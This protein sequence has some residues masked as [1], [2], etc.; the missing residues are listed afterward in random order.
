M[1]SLQENKGHR[2]IAQEPD[3][4]YRLHLS[5]VCNPCFIEAKEEEHYDTSN[6]GTNDDAAVPRVRYPSFLQCEDQRYRPA[7]RNDAADTVETAEALGVRLSIFQGR[8]GEV[9]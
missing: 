9:N 8:H 7:Y 4:K 1:E 3:W 2:R 6:E 5:T